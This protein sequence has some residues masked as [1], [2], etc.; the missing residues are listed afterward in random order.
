MYFEF[1][2]DSGP[3]SEED[4]VQFYGLA[5]SRAKVWSFAPGLSTDSL[6]SPRRG[7]FFQRQRFPSVPLKHPP[8]WQVLLK[9]VSRFFPGAKKYTCVTV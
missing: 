5:H 8:V 7:S 1:Q 3:T 9:T 6:A 2:K 4:L